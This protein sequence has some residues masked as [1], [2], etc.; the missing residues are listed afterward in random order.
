MPPNPYG[1]ARS[2]WI[3]AGIGAPPTILDVY[4]FADDEVIQYSYL[5]GVLVTVLM[6]ERGRTIVSEQRSFQARFEM[7]SID[8][9]VRFSDY[10]ESGKARMTEIVN[11]II[12][13]GT[14]GFNILPNPIDLSA[15]LEAVDDRGWHISPEAILAILER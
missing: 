11:R 8:Y 12:L 9:F 1:W 3:K 15:I 13:G 7:E 2:Y 4:W 5:N 10:E 6:L 14:E